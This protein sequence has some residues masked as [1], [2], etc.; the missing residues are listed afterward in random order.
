MDTKTRICSVCGKNYKYCPKC[1]EFESLPTWMFA[2]CSENCKSIYNTTSNYEDGIISA[3]DAKKSLEKLDLSKSNN[4]GESYK[5]TLK[6]IDKNVTKRQSVNKTY[7]V[8]KE[9]KIENAE[10]NK[11]DENKYFKKTKVGNKDVE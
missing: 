9:S 3:D 6:K 1:R 8:A 7:V 2:F 5:L 11:Q 4:Y 10:A